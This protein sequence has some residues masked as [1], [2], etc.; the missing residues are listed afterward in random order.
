MEKVLEE[1]YEDSDIQPLSKS[2][3]LHLMYRCLSFTDIQYEAFVVRSLRMAAICSRN[4]YG[5]KKNFCAVAGNKTCVAHLICHVSAILN[6]QLLAFVGRNP[7]FLSRS[8]NLIALMQ[9]VL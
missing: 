6:G 2:M 7:V 5:R 3:M 4:I 8:V 9:N 1:V